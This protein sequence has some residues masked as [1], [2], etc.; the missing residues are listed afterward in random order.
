[1]QQQCAF[2]KTASSRIGGEGKPVGKDHHL[3]SAALDWRSTLCPATTATAV[4]A[5]PAIPC[6]LFPKD[7]ILNA[8]VMAIDMSDE[9]RDVALKMNEKA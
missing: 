4:K 1:M 9:A 7:S 8:A 3:S 5:L 6:A 2:L